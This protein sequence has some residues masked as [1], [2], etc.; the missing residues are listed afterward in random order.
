MKIAIAGDIHMCKQSSIITNRGKKYTTR[1]EN[2][3]QSI[4]WFENFAAEH[5]CSYKVYLGDFFNTPELDEETITAVQDILWN[6]TIPNYII[7][8]NHESTELDLKYSSTNVLMTANN[9]II[10]IP[11]IITLN[12]TELCFLPYITEN[13]RE[14]LDSY[15]QKSNKKRIIF[16][17]NDI[18]GIN[19]GIIESKIGF[20]KK[21]IEANCDYFINGHL[22]NGGVVS[23]KI[24]NLGIL[25]GKDFGED[26]FSAVHNVAILDT[27][28]M[29]ISYYENPYAF[30]FY[31]L[32]IKEEADFNK[33]KALKANAVV[34]VKCAGELVE[35]VRK[36]IAESSNIVEARVITVHTTDST[37]IADI[38]T[39]T[40]DH[41]SKFVQCCHEHI[42]NSGLLEEE[43]LEICK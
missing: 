4:N 12:D 38:S 13:D 37:G 23:K 25:T 36:I 35:Q 32:D 26:A 3:I 30:N 31:K 2:C 7:I 39:L 19:Y 21:E 27:D 41:L 9:T 16:S 5:S 29:Q 40:M 15:F 28:T 24:I 17:H 1:L 22:H 11:T 20:S 42:D 43:L 10:A 6:T 18:S 14:N 33:F 34:S 8:G